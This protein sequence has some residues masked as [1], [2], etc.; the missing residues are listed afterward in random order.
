MLGRVAVT[1]LFVGGLLVAGWA[2]PNAQPDSPRRR[3]DEEPLVEY[4]PPRGYVCYRA[5]SPLQIDGRLDE[6]D[7]QKVPWTEDFVDIEGDAKPRPR[8]RTRVKM[9]WDD[10]YFYIAAEMEEPHVWGTLTEHDAIIFQDNDF[11]VFIDPDGDNHEYY[12]FEINALN[13]GWD[14]F[15]TKPY[16]DGGSALH[17]WEIPG[18]KTAVYID[19][20]LNDPR[21]RDRGWSVE[22]AF[23]WAVLREAAHRRTPPRDGEQWRVNFSR[24]EWQH[25]IVDGKYRKVSEQREDNWV[26]SPQGVVNMHRPETW[27]YVQFSAAPPG[28]AHVLPDPA[29]PVRHLLH[30]I[31]YAQHAYRKQHKQ[32]ASKLR[33][34]GLGRLECAGLIGPPL[35]ETTATGFEA[36]AMLRQAEGG[37]QRWHIREDSRIVGEAVGSGP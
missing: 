15:L 31:Y 14:L 12:E 22:L 36:S 23:P 7:W 16:K 34:L 20:T 8:F 11:E 3:S 33:D 28:G 24:V 37:V 21:D 2:A 30:R 1:A 18:L 27:G 25:E 9:L 35:L 5:D 6:P 19:G 29:G 4:V 10:R 32:W 26:W 17:A 13:T